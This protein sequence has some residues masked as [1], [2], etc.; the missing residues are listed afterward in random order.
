MTLSIEE[1]R[2]SFGRELIE[3]GWLIPTLADGVNGLGDP[4]EAVVEGLQAQASRI[5]KQQNYPA[6]NTLRFPPVNSEQLLRRTDYVASFPQLM[7]LVSTFAGER[8]E[9]AALLAAAEAGESWQQQLEPSAFALIPAVCH[10]LYAHLEGRT[11][12]GECYQL[13]GDCFRN[14]P[15]EDP[16]RM[17]AFRM[18][19]YVVLGSEAQARQHRDRWIELGEEMLSALGLEI[20]VESAND[21][22]FGRAGRLLASGQREAK[23]KYELLT[24]VFPGHPTAIASGNWHQDHFGANFSIT[25]ADGSVAHSGCFGFGLERIMLALVARHGL[26]LKD[27]PVPV[28]ALLGL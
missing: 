1:Q 14:E 25:A 3:A 18:R 16:F 7:G 15:S 9:H 26:E 8:K 20:V 4:A 5:A 22:F 11:V 2:I 23:L 12:D 19:E 17:V 27:W 21:P 6:L 13:T 24:E 10:P 28:R